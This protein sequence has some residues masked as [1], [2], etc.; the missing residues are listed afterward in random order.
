[1]VADLANT[2]SSAGREVH[3]ITL[4]DG[5]SDRYEVNPQVR[6]MPLGLVAESNSSWQALYNN[7][8]RVRAV[9]RA[10]R[11]SGATVAVSFVDQMNVVTLWAARSLKNVSVVACERTD[12]RHHQVGRFW[13]WQRRKTYPLAATVVFQ[14]D[15]VAT[16]ARDWLPGVHLEV[17]PNAVP[18]SAVKSPPR[19]RDGSERT[20][21][22]VGRMSPE[23]GADQL[24]K[25]FQ[26]LARKLPDWKL[27]LVGDGPQRPALESLVHHLQL[28]NQVE[29]AGWQ[30]ELGAIYE[31]TSFFVLPSKYEGFP[32]VLLECMARGIPPISFDCPSGPRAIIRDGIDGLLVPPDDIEKLTAAIFE[33]ATDHE[34]LGTL[35]QNAPQVRE[36]F[37]RDTVLRKWDQ[38]LCDAAKAVTPMPTN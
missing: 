2:W 23:K 1:V 3:L 25:A 34:K 30:R 14:T 8:K 17:I 35:S 12:Y 28:D 9:G 36:R 32:N 7:W 4:D 20:I 10:L 22:W 16:A 21:T 5:T 15:E 11:E 29:F 24:V 18:E 6:R 37:G 38:V 27:Q 13:N 33:L 31:R 19:I 26:N